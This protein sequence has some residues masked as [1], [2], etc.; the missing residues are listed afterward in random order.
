MEVVMLERY[1]VRPETID[2]IR[3]S[4]IGELI[5]R[6]VSSMAE[7]G[8]ADRS[9]YRRVPVLM[10]FGAFAKD[11]GADRWDK[12][13]E[14][15]EAFVAAWLENRA[16]HHTANARRKIYNDVRGLVVQMIAIAVPSLHG[17][18]RVGRADPF[19]D[20]APGFFAYLREERG[21]RETSI[22]GYRF[23]LRLFEAYLGRL[24]CHDLAALSPPILAGFVTETASILG[25]KS[26]IGICSAVRTFLR[27][28]HCE[29]L[30]ARDLSHAIQVPQRY[31]LAALPRSIGWDEVRRM[32]EVVDRRTIVGRRDYAILLLLVTYGLRGRE[33]AALSLDDLDWKHDRLLVPERKAN[34]T[35]AYPLSPIVGEAIL[36]YLR[37]GRPKT[38]DRHVFFRHLAPPQPLTDSAVS[39]RAS[40][41]LHEAGIAV[42]R[43]GSHTL[44]HACVQRLVDAGLPFNT[45]GNYVGHSSVSSTQIY[46]KIA[47]EALREVALGDGE[48]L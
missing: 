1:F 44:R 31:R 26:L 5:E 43:A 20:R 6:Y 2:Q 9:V 42:Y 27:Y 40:H 33:I 15:V 3:A 37:D 41:Y 4:W 47:T 7:R 14:H 36:A 45:I 28:L 18:H 25:W 8:Y 10:R 32:L 46:T 21:L 16:T 13:P 48:A 34:H 35:T 39:G 11:R 19:R 12:L 29:G 17:K 30:L 23:H 38:T 22:R 24:G